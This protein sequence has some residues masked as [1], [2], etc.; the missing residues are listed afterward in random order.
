MGDKFIE[1]KVNVK[2]LVRLEKNVA[3]IYKMLQ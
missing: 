3:D 2:V 1:Q